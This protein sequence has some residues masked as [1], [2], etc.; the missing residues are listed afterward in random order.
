ME[1]LTGKRFLALRC[2]VVISA[3]LV[4]GLSL[5]QE[6]GLGVL[7]ALRALQVLGVLRVLRVWWI[8]LI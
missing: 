4:L 3:G 1:L 2:A 7:R 8:G 6:V 5:P